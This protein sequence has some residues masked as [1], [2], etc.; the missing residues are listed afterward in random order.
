M[1]AS[2]RGTVQAIEQDS[3]IIET[4]GIGYQIFTTQLLLS[5]VELG[6]ALFLHTLQHVRE[7]AIILFGFRELQEKTSFITLQSV[8]GIGPKAALAILNATSPALLAE[9]IQTE[10]ISFLTDL[11]GVGKKTA[12]RLIVELKDK[13]NFL[14]VS[15][16]K[17][18]SEH[19][20]QATISPSFIQEVTDTLLTLGYQEREIRDVL[21]RIRKDAQLDA[22]VETWVKR[23][24]REFTRL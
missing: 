10:D 6:Q 1:I 5:Q 14:P 23:A 3:I 18:E 22:T 20:K 19:R 16:A 21:K 17:T 7:D 11:P 15:H 2:I 9:A 24:L 12:Q 8:T 4:H 13:F